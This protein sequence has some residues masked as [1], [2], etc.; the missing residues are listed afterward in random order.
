I[1][2]FSRPQ[3]VVWA[4]IFPDSQDDFVLLRQALDRLRLSDSSLSFEEESSGVLGRGFRCGFLGMLHLEI[5]TERLRR[6]FELEIIITAPSIAY[7]ITYPDGAVE[8]IYAASRFPDYGANVKIK[9]PWILGQII[10]PADYTGN[11]LTLLYEHESSVID[12][13]V[14]GDGRTLLTIEMP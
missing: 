6:E 13:E 9:E 8:S 10:A 2:G 14:F 7:E 3:P 1:R 12:T 11:I 4:S 5:A